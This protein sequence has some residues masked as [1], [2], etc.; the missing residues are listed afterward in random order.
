MFFDSI[1]PTIKHPVIPE[2]MPPTYPLFYHPGSKYRVAD[3]ILPILAPML[4]GSDEYREPFIGAGSIAVAVMGL[5]PQVSVWLNDRDP[6]I[7]SL[8]AA[9]RDTPTRVR[10]QV[11]DFHQ[12]SVAAFELFGRLIKARATVPRYADA[13]ARLGFYQLAWSMMRS[14]GWGQGPRGGWDQHRPIIGERWSQRH[15]VQKV[16]TI[17]DRLGGRAETKISCWDFEP[18]ITDTSRRAVLFLD[19]PY[20]GDKKLYRCDFGEN[21][22]KRLADLLKRTPHGWLLTYE[23]HPSVWELYD[24]WSTIKLRYKARGVHF[25]PETGAMEEVDTLVI[26]NLP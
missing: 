19:P 4:D 7:A 14:R 17:A 22:H 8:W 10:Q 26:S 1:D 2:T 6:A 16:R 12:P 3:R 24:G 11:L 9:T 23:D 25:D 15:I 5:Y 20:F 13:R 18:L 21:D